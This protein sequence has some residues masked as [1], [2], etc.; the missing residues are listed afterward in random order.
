M[1]ADHTNTVFVTTMV[2]A[3]HFYC[4]HCQKTYCL[5]K[6]SIPPIRLPEGFVAQKVSYVVKGICSE[7]AR[8]SRKQ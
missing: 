4:E 2:I 1:E 6:D 7:C 8:K 5:D 3:C